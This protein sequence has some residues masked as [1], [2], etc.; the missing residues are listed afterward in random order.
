MRH[1]ALK[2]FDGKQLKDDIM[3]GL[4]AAVVSLPLALAFGITSGAGPLA[5]IYGA[6]FVGFFAAVFGSTKTLISSTTAPMTVVMAAVLSQYAYNPALA[7]TVVMIGGVMQIALGKLKIG[8]YVDYV[9]FS[10]VSGFMSAVGIIIIIL[11]IPV[12]TG[13]MGSAQGAFS[14]LLSL[15]EYLGNIHPNELLIGMATFLVVV[16][17][18]NPL[19]KI[20]PSYLWG[21]VLGSLRH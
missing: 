5:G 16:L 14:I 4:M 8:S 2:T 19:K 13:Y 1:S 18:P 6:V 15:Q 9:P 10:V 11:Q 12:L 20:F 3:G 17:V 7:F 21:L